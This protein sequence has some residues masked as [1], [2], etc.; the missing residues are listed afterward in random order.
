MIKELPL[1][2]VLIGGD[3]DI[4]WY[5]QAFEKILNG[6]NISKLQQMFPE[7]DKN[8]L[9]SEMNHAVSHVK[10]RSGRKNRK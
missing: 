10:K 4:M 3:G 2:Y 1:P 6:K 5:N 9:P 7:L 8:L